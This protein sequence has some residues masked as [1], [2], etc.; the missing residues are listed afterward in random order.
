MIKQCEPISQTPFM[1]SRPGTSLVGKTPTSPLLLNRRDI[2]T[3]HIILPDDPRPISAIRYQNKYY[4]YLKFYPA[5]EP[6]ERAARRLIEKGEAVVLTQVPKGLIL[7]VF[8]PDAK[9]ASPK[10]FTS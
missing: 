10:S 3:C 5:T 4:S 8:E 7:W 1:Q 6:A 2:R 9:L